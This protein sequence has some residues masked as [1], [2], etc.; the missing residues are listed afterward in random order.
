L[1]FGGAHVT[2]TSPNG[3][4]GGRVFTLVE[5]LVIL[6]IIALLVA[7]LLL[8]LGAARNAQI[9]TLSKQVRGSLTTAPPS[10]VSAPAAVVYTIDLS[11]SGTTTPITAKSL[12]NKYLKV[13]V[14][15][16]L[17]GA[18]GAQFAGGGRSVTVA[19]NPADGTATAT[20]TPVEDGADT[21]TVS[22][23]VSRLDGSNAVTID[24]PGTVN[25]ETVK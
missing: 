3:N 23:V 1:S 2:A 13:S 8:T 15:F 7:I 16:T 17:T 4:K 11:I 20:I 14:N 12:F 22:Y 19:M 10:T 24:D 25:F 9:N 6:A 5:F 18:G 21:L